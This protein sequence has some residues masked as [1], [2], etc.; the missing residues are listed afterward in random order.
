M[1]RGELYR[2]YRPGG[3][4]RRIRTFVIVSRQVLIDSRFSTVVCAPVFSSCEGLSTQVAIGPDEG[5]KHE[6]WI[7]CDSLVSLRKTDLTNYVGTLSPAR[8]AELNRA[9]RMALDL[10]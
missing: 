1:K 2:V 4:P 6:S 3:D 7:M 10:P 8:V 5:M 9:L